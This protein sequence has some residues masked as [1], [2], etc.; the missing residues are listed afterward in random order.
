MLKYSRHRNGL[1]K[2]Q[3]SIEICVLEEEQ[4]LKEMVQSQVNQIL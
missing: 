4:E 3:L 1:C 2:G